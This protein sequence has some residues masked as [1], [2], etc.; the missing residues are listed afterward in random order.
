MVT[1]EQDCTAVAGAEYNE[2]MF[3]LIVESVKETHSEEQGTS[4]RR[5]DYTVRHTAHRSRGIATSPIPQKQNNPGTFLF[6]VLIDMYG[7]W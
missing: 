7:C 4:S 5:T 2:H 3:S 6:I 1:E